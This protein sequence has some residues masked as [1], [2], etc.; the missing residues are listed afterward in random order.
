MMGL[1]RKH[2]PPCNSRALIPWKTPAYPTRRGAA[3]PHTQNLW[4]G[5]T[6]ASPATS[7]GEETQIP[8]K[9]T[10]ETSGKMGGLWP[11]QSL[12]PTAQQG[13]YGAMQLFLIDTGGWEKGKKVFNKNQGKKSWQLTACGSKHYLQHR[14]SLALC[15]QHHSHEHCPAGLESCDVAP[16]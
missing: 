15:V 8:A 9:D 16:D 2:W 14:N 5:I 12:T 1:K 7:S 10:K 6:A 11:L 4:T 13:T 3:A